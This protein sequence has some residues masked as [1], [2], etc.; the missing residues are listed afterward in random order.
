MKIAHDR[1]R[2][3]SGILRR[4]G[5]RQSGLSIFLSRDQQFCRCIGQLFGQGEG[6]T[7]R[8]AVAS[9]ALESDLRMVTQLWLISGQLFTAEIHER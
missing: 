5:Q 9:G 7:F 6:G 8:D 2:G 4:A 3:L 1:I